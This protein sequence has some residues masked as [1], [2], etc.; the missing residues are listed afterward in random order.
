MKPKTVTAYM[1]VDMLPV[2]RVRMILMAC[3]MKLA[4]EAI[5]AAPPM[6]AILSIA[7]YASPNAR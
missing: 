4:V 3:G 5:A 7:I 6:A 1:P 2:S